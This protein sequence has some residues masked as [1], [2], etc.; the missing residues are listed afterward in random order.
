M[1]SPKNKSK[2]VKKKR[3]NSSDTS[4]LSY[5]PAERNPERY[6]DLLPKPVVRLH[7]SSSEE[8]PEED[9]EKDESDDEREKDL[10]TLR[11]DYTNSL[12]SNIVNKSLLISELVLGT[13][14]SWELDC[15]S[16]DVLY[17]KAKG[18]LFR[19]IFSWHDQHISESFMSP[20]KT[21]K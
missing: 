13:I 6:S 15:L 20:M 21:L 2:I 14:Q 7:E 4:S 9:K 3:K 17:L 19:S 1:K 10:R 8:E 16:I 5:S 11:Y 12:N 18:N